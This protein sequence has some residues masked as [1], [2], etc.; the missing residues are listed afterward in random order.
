MALLELS[1]LY[2]EIAQDY[3]LPEAKT[4]CRFRF[5]TQL[6]HVTRQPVC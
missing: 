2:Q 3:E 4:R 6:E 1:C 5:S